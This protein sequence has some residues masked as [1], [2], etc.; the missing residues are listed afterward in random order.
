[1]SDANVPA[2]LTTHIRDELFR[3]TNRWA[4]QKSICNRKNC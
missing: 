3:N 2:F 4:V 1:M